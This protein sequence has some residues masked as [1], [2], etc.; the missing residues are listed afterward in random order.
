MATTPAAPALVGSGTYTVQAG[1][2]LGAIAAKFD[3]WTASLVAANHLASANSI[4]VGQVLQV[5][6]QGANAPKPAPVAAPAPAPAHAPAPAPA[7]PAPVASPPA[8]GS[9]LGT[10]VVT[11]YDDQGAT[12]SGAMAG[13][14]TVAVDPSV[15]PLGST[16]TIQGVGTRVAQD[17][18]GAI[19]GHRLDV[20]EPSAAQ[21]DAFGVQTLEVTQP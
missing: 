4:V 14:Q 21:C 9:S 5:G 15:I 2:N 11:C 20:W 3:T 6:G 10:F 17:T 12:A 16:I 19:K 7:P 8:A 18:G 1:D 13:P